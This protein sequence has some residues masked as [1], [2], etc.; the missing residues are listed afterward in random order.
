MGTYEYTF[1]R[2]SIS[3]KRKRRFIKP[4]FIV[5]PVEIVSIES[6]TAIK[7]PLSA[8]IDRKIWAKVRRR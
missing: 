1:A 7:P 4:S 8:V 3:L 2:T 6:D 5:S